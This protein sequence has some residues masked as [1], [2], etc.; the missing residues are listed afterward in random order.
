MLTF[1]RCQF[2]LLYFNKRASFFNLQAGPQLLHRVR[3]IGMRSELLQSCCCDSEPRE[4]EMQSEY[5]E[6]HE[7]ANGKLESDIPNY[8]HFA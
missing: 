2:G 6:K 3:N 7:D 5:K 4:S 8:I 1:M